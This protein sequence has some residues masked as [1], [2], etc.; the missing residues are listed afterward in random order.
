[1]PPDANR[2]ASL[3]KLFDIEVDPYAPPPGRRRKADI[4]A[5]KSVWMRISGMPVEGARTLLDLG[6]Q[7]LHEIVGRSPESLLEELSKRK[8]PHKDALAS[9]RLA[10]YVAET[11]DPDPNRL[12]LEAWR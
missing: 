9:L 3:P 4:E 10:V 2:P 11:S 6:F 8:E 1:M 12:R 7:N 5:L